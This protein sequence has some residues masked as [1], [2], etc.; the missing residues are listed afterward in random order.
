VKEIF[1]KCGPIV[2]VKKREG[3]N[4]YT[5]SPAY[6]QYFVLF[7]DLDHAKLAIKKYD[8]SIAFGARPLSVEFWVSPQEL[9][10]ERE[11]RSLRQVIEMMKPII[12][13]N[14]GGGNF[15]RGPRQDY[16]QQRGG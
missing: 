3:K 2:S 14:G 4:Y 10:A 1:E 7:A 11:Q 8:Q 15:Q 16:Q 6:V 9:Q 13:Q 5:N 12:T